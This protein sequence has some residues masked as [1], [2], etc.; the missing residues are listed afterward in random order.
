MTVI[1]VGIETDW[2]YGK[3]RDGGGWRYRVGRGG[4]HR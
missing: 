4:R 1:E 2:R 3:T